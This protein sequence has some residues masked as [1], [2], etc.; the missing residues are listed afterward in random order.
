MKKAR[1]LPSQ[2][3]LKSVLSY[4]LATGV[5][6][7]LC[8]PEAR[9]EW[10]TRY[11]G[12]IAGKVSGGYRYLRFGKHTFKS[13]RLIWK[14]MTGNDPLG[15]IDHR[16]TIGTDDRWDNLRDSTRGQNARNRNAYA[17][18]GL[19]KGVALNCN[20]TR[21]A[22]KIHIDYRTIHLGV[23]DTVTA[24]ASAYDAAARLHHGEFARPN[25]EH[26]AELP[27]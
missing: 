19:P 18:S 27:R 4:D 25:E 20:K 6:I 5:L 21:Y 7:W 3:H 8:R 11:A 10:N 14:Y 9:T 24:A 13:A 1:S 15:E 16:N 23:F 2:Q 26:L 22:A 17:K 12:R